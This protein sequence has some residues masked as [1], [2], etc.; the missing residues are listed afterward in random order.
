MQEVQTLG[1]AAAQIEVT[2][3]EA[4]SRRAGRRHG[5]STP[6]IDLTLARAWHTGG[7]THLPP[8]PCRGRRW[9]LHVISQQLRA[10]RGHIIHPGT[11]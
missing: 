8:A 1:G 10:A 7:W 11:L 4:T 9:R 3:F 2:T 6:H 5:D